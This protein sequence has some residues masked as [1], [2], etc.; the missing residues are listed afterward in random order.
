[1]IIK[2]QAPRALG[3]DEPLYHADHSRPVTRRDFLAQ[4]FCA[5]AGTVLGGS[6]LSMF[7][8]PRKAHA[9]SQDLIDAMSAAGCSS[10]LG[11]GKIP[12]IC[13]DLAGGVNIAG[14]NV[15]IGGQGG[16]MDFLS[17][18]GYDKL[19]LPG[20]MIPGVAEVNGAGSSESGTS[21][22]DHTDTTLGLA[23]HSDS[24]F[25]RGILEKLSPGTAA[26]INGAIIPARSE[27][28]TGNNPHNPMYG[29]ARA[30]AEGSIL[31]LIG[32]RSSDSGGN[33][34]APMAMIDPTIR[35]TKV[36][37]PTDVT[38]M[39]DI[40]D[41]VGLLNQSDA[42]AVMES[43][44]RLSNA[45][46]GTVDTRLTNDAVIK[47]LIECGYLSS[48]DLAERFGD[49]NTLN[50][51]DRN[52]PSPIIVS[53]NG[54]IFSTAEFDGSSEFRKTASVMKMVIDG[55]SGAGTITM[56][57]YDYHTGER[58]T[59]E[60]RDLRAGRCMGACLEYAARTNTPLMMYVMSDGSV[61]SNGRIDNSVDGRGKGEWTGDNQST[62]SSF[63]MVY[64]PNGRPQLLGATPEEQ[65]R[66][67]QIGFMRNDASVE[68]AATPAANNVNLL[69]ETVILNYMALHGEQGNFANLFPT[70]GLG[71]AALMDSLTA[72][73]PIVNGTI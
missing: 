47:D 60:I 72:F 25:L 10:G 46:L 64:N 11:A 6:V 34:M 15:L 1:M 56:G 58:A 13:F 39:V 51:D 21:N 52:A 37:R 53:D 49:P 30:G 62:A 41:L 45:K 32:S 55:F 35:P 68:T 24:A 71:N 63:F 43:V 36:D 48:A 69:V 19:G 14:S 70:N 27:N 5:G 16:Q 59:G 23:F 61:A 67:Q 4:G 65:A 29:I 54:G 42:V 17:T 66:H 22:G 40:G 20:D 73:Q 2:K 18:A 9:L 28:D 31:S 50:P 3:L 12:F 33:S 57:G 44:Y 38:G 8:S 7:A 26:N